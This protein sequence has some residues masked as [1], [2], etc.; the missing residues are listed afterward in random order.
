MMSPL[1]TKSNFSQVAYFASSR[2]KAYFQM[3]ATFKCTMEYYKSKSGYLILDFKIKCFY[4]IF[5]VYFQ[6]PE[7]SWDRVSKSFEK[8]STLIVKDRN[9]SILTR[10]S[11]CLLLI[12]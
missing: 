11:P 10:T 2:C 6:T 9:I 7:S 12:F 5:A 4:D 1:F 3:C 8:I